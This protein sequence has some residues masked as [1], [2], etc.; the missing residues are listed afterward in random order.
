MCIY[1]GLSVSFLVVF[2]LQISGLFYN[3]MIFW[4]HQASTL[5]EYMTKRYGGQRIRMVLSVI[6]VVMYIFTK[7]SVSSSV[8]VEKVQRYS[9]RSI[10]CQTC[11]NICLFN[12]YRLHGFC[13]ISGGNWWKLWPPQT[14]IQ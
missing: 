7:N 11:L 8:L 2:L 5:P 14:S 1:V 4:C 10:S 3:I 13:V 6:S 12:R 9:E